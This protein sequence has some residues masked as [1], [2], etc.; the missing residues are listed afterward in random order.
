MNREKLQR[1]AQGQYF[2]LLPKEMIKVSQWEEGDE[3][4]IWLGSEV[5]PRKE[6]L[7]L[8]KL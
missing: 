7:V 2:L 5:S 4:E 1:T 6:D 3:I 8:R